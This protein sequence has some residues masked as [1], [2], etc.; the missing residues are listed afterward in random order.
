MNA[1]YSAA[2]KQNKLEAVEGDLKKIS[3]LYKTDP[4]FKDY[5][6]NPLVNPAQ[7]TA[8]FEKELESKLEY[9]ADVM[10]LIYALFILSFDSLRA[11]FSSTFLV[12]FLKRKKASCRSSATL[13][14]K[15]AIPINFRHFLDRNCCLM[16]DASSRPA[17]SRYMR[18]ICSPG[19][20]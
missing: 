3:S 19:F 1:L 4:K 16:F 9:K 14:K 11:S 6:I 15:D 7:K 20:D 5:M 2:S 17:S 18:V 12:K 8:V 10:Q 13:S